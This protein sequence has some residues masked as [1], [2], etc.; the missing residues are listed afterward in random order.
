MLNPIPA[1][2]PEGE[3]VVRVFGIKRAGEV[4]EKELKYTVDRTPPRG[5]LEIN[6]AKGIRLLRVLSETGLERVVAYLPGGIEIR[7][8]ES[9]PGCYS[10]AIPKS[11]R[12]EM[13]VVMMDAAHN[14]A[15]LKC[16]LR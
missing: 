12:G 9:E 6:L 1:D 16:S 13:L 2:A 3:Y 5:R 8:K 4:V 15:E 11:A 7:L 14:R 10:V